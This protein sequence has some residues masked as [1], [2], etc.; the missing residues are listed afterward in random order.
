MLLSIITLNYKKSHLTLAC[1]ASVY[2]QYK[3]EFVNNEME[4][5]IVD[6]DSGD[7]SVSILKDAIKKEGYKNFHVIANT[8]N[9]GFGK[10]CNLGAHSA[11]GNYFLFL[12][13]DTVVKDQGLLAMAQ[14]MDSHQAVGI[15][16]GQLRNHDGSLQA[17]TGKFY[18][19]Y[20]AFL[21]LIG[22]Q[23][24]GLLDSSPNKITEVEWVKGG[25]LMIR[26]NIFEKIS[27][28]DENIFM[29]TEDM[30]LC[31][32]AHLQGYR[33]F[34]Y[35]DVL[36][37]HKEHGS[38]NRTFAIVNICKNLLYFYKK[39]RS[40]SDYQFLFFILKTKAAILIGIGKITGNSYLSS[41]YEQVFKA[42]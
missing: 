20:Y 13:N 26:K 32:R 40:K 27:G 36:V 16:G 10:G 15:L 28:F 33:I 24:Y 4:F 19:P 42:L 3:K 35:P 34:F 18:T 21:L 7:D 17:S 25:L 11:K 22:M 9:A 2:E 23:K 1:M 8:E 6:N 41:T 38:T 29:Y 5:I 30:E 39:H 31:Y 37:L 14:Y 12:N